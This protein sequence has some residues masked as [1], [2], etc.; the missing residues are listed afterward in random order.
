[1]R[2]VGRT[3]FARRCLPVVVGVLLLACAQGW[4]Q[5]DIVK[6]IVVRGNVNIESS[7]ILAAVTNTKVGDP[8]SEEALQ[9]DVNNVQDMGFFEPGVVYGIPEPVEAGV[10]IV[11]EVT[12][13]PRIKSVEF[14]GNTVVSTQ[15]LTGEQG[16]I[17][18]P[19]DVFNVFTL[20]RGLENIY[21]LYV[22]KGYRVAIGDVEAPVE[23]QQ[24]NGVLRIHLQEVRV[25]SIEPVGLTKTKHSVVL[26]EIHTTPG[27][28]YNVDTLR[29]DQ[30]RLLNKGFFDE[31]DGVIIAPKPGSD[32]ARVVV[33]YEFK[34]K[35]TGLFN[36]G[37]GY[38]S[39]D[40]LV[41]YTE[42]S[43][44]NLRG[45]GQQANVKWEFGGINSYEVGFSEP[46]I[47]DRH[48]GLTV[49]AFNKLLNRFIA[50]EF[51]A[52]GLSSTRN[53][54][55]VGGNVTLSVPLNKQETTW[56]WTTLRH[57]NV[58]G[59]FEESGLS[60]IEPFYNQGR[61]SSVATKGVYDS[62][63]YYNY[64]T[65]GWRNSLTLEVAGRALGGERSF[66]KYSLDV[67]KYVEVGRGQVAAGR[68]MFGVASGDVP[69]FETFVVGGAETLRGYAED[70]FWGK[71]MFLLN[72]EYRAP[73]DSPKR[74]NLI[75]VVFV[76][77]G[78]A[79]GGVWSTPDHSI[80][81]PAEHQKFSGRLGYGIG[82]R[83][84][85][86]VGPIRMDL[87]FSSEGQEPHISIGQ[88]F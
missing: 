82:L 58:S 43:E 50:S 60:I 7:R 41:G 11:I 86:P 38:S 9:K 12:E 40:K 5:G 33:V 54:K 55:R 18:R 67:R 47:N 49:N 42:V 1:V 37:V 73:L 57:E 32:V 65:Q 79:W 87:G 68:M 71:R 72:L 13:Y 26:R 10:R 46:W 23:A 30:R 39:R 17:L 56:V 77:W 52:A 44:L 61:V 25:E 51:A 88:M 74:R 22:E 19:G 53:E 48:W 35:Q 34:E 70:R 85:T 4:P 59:R 31:Q 24:W 16:V 2:V 8:Y 21:A 64:P 63:D 84:V 75:G 6:E 69:L 36:V 80:L 81:Y 27:D 45:L 3:A 66:E 76:D 29:E 78:D 28:L 14:V 20:R 15:E 83:V 62:R